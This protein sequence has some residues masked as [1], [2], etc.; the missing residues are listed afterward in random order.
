MRPGKSVPNS[1]ELTRLIA[2]GLNPA[3]AL[4]ISLGNRN[5]AFEVARAQERRQVHIWC[6]GRKNI[7]TALT[8][9]WD[10]S[11]ANFYLVFDGAYASECPSADFVVIDVDVDRVDKKLTYAASR[12]KSPWHRR[13]KSKSCEIAYRWLHGRPVTPPLIREIEGQI[14]IEGGTHRFHLA[15]HYG[16]T[17]MPF[18]VRRSEKAAVIALIESA[19]ATGDKSCGR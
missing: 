7:P 6:K 18:L 14:H 19:T 4:D 2:L 11:P 15:K 13:Y 3:T 5:E 17:R 9:V 1:D 10:L 16:S 12:D 8:P